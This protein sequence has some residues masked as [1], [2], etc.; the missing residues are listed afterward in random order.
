MNSSRDRRRA[1]RATHALYISLGALATT[2]VVLTPGLLTTVLLATLLAVPIG[3]CFVG[4]SS[5]ALAYRLCSRTDH[6]DS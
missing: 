3:T 4:T 2:L 5:Y 6:D 1:H